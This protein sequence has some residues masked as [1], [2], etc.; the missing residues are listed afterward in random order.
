VHGVGR[1]L[2][3]AAAFSLAG[4]VVLTFAWQIVSPPATVKTD[5][6]REKV[7]AARSTFDH[8]GAIQGPFADGPAVTRQC[9]T[10]HKDAAKKFMKTVHWNWLG[11]EV[12]VPG[13]DK[14]VRIGKANLI[15]NF[16][17]GIQGNWAGCT[18]CHAGYGWDSADFD[19][20]K[21]DRVDCLVCH[22]HTGKYRKPAGMAGNPAPGTDL[23]A[24]AQSVGRPTRQNCGACH[25][26]GGGGNAVKHGDMDRTMIYPNERI[27]IHMG[28]ENLECVD[29]HRSKDHVI[30]G[31]SIT[32]STEDSNHVRCID[33]HDQ[34]PHKSD[35]LNSHTRTVACQSCHIPHFAVET[36][37][38]LDWRWDEAGND[39]IPDNPHTYLKIKGRFIYG[40]MVVPEY[41]WFNGSADRHLQGDKVVPGQ[42]VDLNKPHGNIKDPS[43]KIWPFKVHTGNQPYDTEYRHLL[44]PNTFGKGGFWTEFKWPYAFES[45]VKVT[46]LKFSGKFDFIDT[47]QYW[48]LSHMVQAKGKA[49][50][51]ADCHT[52]GGRM[53]WKDLGYPGDPYLRGG[54]AKEGLI[55]PPVSTSKSTGGAR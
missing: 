9:L 4:L 16:C 1:S 41:L 43:A 3:T 36:P 19:F 10:C 49:L 14:P 24:V 18:G 44:I 32:V 27:D 47:A 55:P 52:K 45:N 6:P 2:L 5:A 15:N 31:R 40:K 13:H 25:F 28:R 35:R 17:I 29:C 21:E 34:T 33:C 11:D 42:R 48:P 54:R 23:L 51:C 12:K 50:Q 20:T 38:K 46:G 37:T 26:T 53:N 39:N 7:P 30:A 8:K 22:E